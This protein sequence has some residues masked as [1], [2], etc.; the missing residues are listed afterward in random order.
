MKNFFKDNDTEVVTTIR[1]G[2]PGAKKLQKK[3]PDLV[4]LRRYKNRRTGES[5]TTIEI[6]LKK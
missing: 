3:Y 2:N 1:A 5:V 6:P 4:K